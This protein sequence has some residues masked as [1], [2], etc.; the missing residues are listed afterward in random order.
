MFKVILALVPTNT[1]GVEF[2]A[3]TQGDKC[4]PTVLTRE[5]IFFFSSMEDSLKRK[6]GDTFLAR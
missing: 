5:A 1:S 4:P 2:V 3:D 6:G